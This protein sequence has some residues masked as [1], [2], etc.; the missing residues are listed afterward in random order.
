MNPYHTPSLPS[1]KGE[2]IPLGKS[3]DGIEAVWRKTPTPVAAEGPFKHKAAFEKGPWYVT[4]PDDHQ[5]IF[6]T[7]PEAVAAT[8]NL[9]RLYKFAFAAGQ[10]AGRK[11]K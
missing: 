9:N 4:G 5:Y 10:E 2:R 1:P 7:E 11:G 3:V 8:K 6:Q